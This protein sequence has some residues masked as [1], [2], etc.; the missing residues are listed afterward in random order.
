VCVC[1]C[2]C[3]GLVFIMT[4][5]FLQNAKSSLLTVT[6]VIKQEAIPQTDRAMHS[7]SKSCQLLHELTNVGTNCTA[8][9]Q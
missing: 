1:V 2:V 7:Q 8:N 4:N 6:G 3:V 9:S 5:I